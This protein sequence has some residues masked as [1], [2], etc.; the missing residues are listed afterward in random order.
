MRTIGLALIAILAASGCKRGNAEDCDKGC[1]NYYSLHFWEKSDKQLAATPEA[2]RDALRAKM[3]VELDG[4][5]KSGDLNMCVSQCQKAGAPDDV[6]C[7]IKARTVA[8]VEAC[9][10]P[11]GDD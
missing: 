7:M 10:G 8:E 5:L 4:K 9:V 2:E 11:G 3:L 6:Q 1:R